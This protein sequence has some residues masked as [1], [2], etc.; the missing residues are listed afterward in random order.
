MSDG[1]RLLAAIWA[2]PADDTPRLMYADW[3]QEQ[4]QHARAEFIRLQCEL[5]HL[6][7][8]DD[9][10]RIARLREREG[11]LWSAHAAEWREKLKK[12]LRHVDFR[13][14]FPNPHPLRLTGDQFLRL[15][16]RALDAAPQWSVALR[17]MNSTFDAVF[18]SP[19]I[20]RV[21]TLSFEDSPHIYDQFERFA[22][23]HLLRNVT[24]LRMS[25]QQGMPASLAAFLDGP[26]TASLAR[27]TFGEM[28]AFRF[29]ALRGSRAAGRLRHL[30]VILFGKLP[31]APLFDADAFPQLRSLDVSNFQFSYHR[32]EPATL[33]LFFTGHPRTQLRALNLLACGITNGGA[34]QLA[35]WPGLA[36]LR[37]LNLDR[38]LFGAAG[39]L[40]LARSPFAGNLKHLELDGWQLQHLPD[41]RAELDARFGP[42]LHY[43][44][45]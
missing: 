44:K 36:N 38:N 35:E 28:D 31:D 1:D 39:L 45:P 16:P 11:V 22:T 41:V 5:A 19:L 43:Y 13:R 6:D 18:A 8:W 27:V 30:Q 21:G 14:G 9:T 12:D 4:G 2:H 15:K 32:D 33:D 34:K 23:N 37:W 26:A 7:E 10:D 42:A 29:A 17:S 25:G 40:A 20:L 3:L 24:D